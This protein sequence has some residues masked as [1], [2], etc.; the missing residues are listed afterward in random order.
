MLVRLVAN[1]GKSVCKGSRGS[2]ASMGLARDEQEC[3]APQASGGT[4]AYKNCLVDLRVDSEEPGYAGFGKPSLAK[5]FNF[6]HVRDH[7]SR[8]CCRLQGFRCEI[9]SGFSGCFEGLVTQPA[10]VAGLSV[11]A[12]GLQ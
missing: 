5:R 12:V 11:A 7:G 6:C 2:K 3:S 1:P 8:L 10:D 9:S 4:C